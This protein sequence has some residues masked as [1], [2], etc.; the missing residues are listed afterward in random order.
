VLWF[1]LTAA[2]VTGCGGGEPRQQSASDAKIKEEQRTI[3]KLESK[4]EKEQIEGAREAAKQFGES[5]K[6]EKQ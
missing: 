4:N 5:K 6:E 1:L 3:R 2:I